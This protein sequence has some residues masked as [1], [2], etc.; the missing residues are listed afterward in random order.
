VGDTIAAARD[1]GFDELSFL[2]A[3]LSSKAFNRPEPW[4]DERKTDIAIPADELPAFEDAIERARA[5]E[6]QAFESGF[7]VGGVASLMRIHRYYSAVAGRAKF[8]KVR[9]NAP[10]VSAVLEPDGAVRPCFFHDAY[11][12]EIGDLRDTL[13]SPR[14]IGF[15]KALDVDTNPTCQR[16]VCSLNLPI[17]EDV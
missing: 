8:P 12:T 9:C 4:S 14:A 5:G 3:D 11:P 2:A 6:E 16:C 17:M 1:I 15:R 13:N 10:W 7:I